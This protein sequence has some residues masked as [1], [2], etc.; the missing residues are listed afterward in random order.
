MGTDIKKLQGLIDNLEK[1]KAQEDKKKKELEK[2]NKAVTNSLDYN[3][4]TTINN[5]VM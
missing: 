2:A 4:N 5:N 3:E 1:V